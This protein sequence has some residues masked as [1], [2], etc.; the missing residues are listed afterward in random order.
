VTSVMPVIFALETET[1]NAIG[2]VCIAVIIIVLILS[3]A[4]VFVK[5]GPPAR[6]SV[7]TPFSDPPMWTYET[8]T[9][10]RVPA[11]EEETSADQDH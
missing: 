4:R 1:A 11:E 5:W 8:R 6:G 3:V 2:Y 7:Y 10:R 9:E